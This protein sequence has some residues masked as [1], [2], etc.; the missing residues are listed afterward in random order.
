[1]A[2]PSRS[3]G[4]YGQ[5]CP[6]ALAAE[7]LCRRWT[8]LIVSRLID[9][10][11]TFNE[12]HQG[13]PRISPSLLSSRLKELEDAGIVKRIKGKANG[14]YS[15]QVTQAGRDLEDI[16]TSLA[17]WGQHWARDN[18]MDDLDLGFLAWS[19][20][21]RINNDLMPPGRTV[22]EFEFSGVP[23]DFRRFWLVNHDGKVDMC[24]KHPGYETDLLVR[25][26]LRTFVEVWRGF[27]DLSAEIRASRI[28]LTGPQALKKAF[29]Q[30][31]MLSMF[32][33]LKRKTPGR[34]QR[35]SAR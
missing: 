10:C 27:R 16:I 9:G 2:K 15:Y 3:A 5:Y 31:L 1:M 32:A 22:L 7:L 30:W 4:S 14:R 18:Q 20:S 24:F 17:V 28:R 34:E 19:M 6:L 12:I 21:L 8:I 29:P 11:T 26:D 23:T 13:V 33:H 25:A 35:L